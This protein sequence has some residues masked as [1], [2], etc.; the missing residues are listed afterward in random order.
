MS[1]FSSANYSVFGKK[2]ASPSL[3]VLLQATATR[4]ASLYKLWCVIPGDIEPSLEALQ[5]EKNVY[6]SFVV[7][8]LKD[9]PSEPFIGCN[10]TFSTNLGLIAEEIAGEKPAP[11]DNIYGALLFYI[12]EKYEKSISY[13]I[14]NV[15]MQVNIFTKL[16]P[17]NKANVLNIKFE[18]MELPLTSGITFRTAVLT[19]PIDE[20]IPLIKQLVHACAVLNA[21]NISHN[22]LHFNN[23][24]VIDGKTSLS[25]IGIVH[26]CWEEIILSYPPLHTLVLAHIR[27]AINCWATI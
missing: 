14:E 21:N 1:N 12:Q 7:P 13:T 27:N 24:F 4:P 11:N 23:I 9:S 16:S 15:K 25:L 17:S 19:Q 5:Y 10:R 26:I 6:D 2:S 8:L 22:D 18:G 3:V 20:V